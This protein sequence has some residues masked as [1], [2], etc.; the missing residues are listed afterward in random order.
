M[1]LLD[2]SNKGRWSSDI[3]VEMVISS[4]LTT[5]GHHQFARRRII[6]TH[7]DGKKSQPNDLNSF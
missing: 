4:T 5:A 1:F 6:D 3:S 7:K 2:L